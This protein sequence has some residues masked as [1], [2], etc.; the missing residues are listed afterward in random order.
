MVVLQ[1]RQPVATALAWTFAHG[2]TDMTRPVQALPVYAL[3]LAPLPRAATTPMFLVASVAH[4]ARD[5]GILP[6]VVL[7]ASLGGLAAARRVDVAWTILTVYMCL[8]HVPAHL[9]RCT[10]LARALFWAWSVVFAWIGVRGDR[11]VVTDA[12]QRV[13]V[14]HM[15]VCSL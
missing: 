4:F 5:V 1:V 11:V 2:V 13:G 12:M 9:S 10:V 14:A 6:S 3:A 15:V 7:H 8:V